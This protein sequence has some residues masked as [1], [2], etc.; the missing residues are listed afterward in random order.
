MFVG[1]RAS[2]RRGGLVGFLG[3]PATT[4]TTTK[5]STKLP[6]R[7]A[8]PTVFCRRQSYWAEDYDYSDAYA[9]KKDPPKRKPFTL[10]PFRKKALKF[11]DDPHRYGVPKRPDG[12]VRVRE[13]VRFPISCIMKIC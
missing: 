13:M 12:F 10:T 3:F 6:V 5:T 2:C 4:A 8:T 7:K 9:E 11:L 1:L